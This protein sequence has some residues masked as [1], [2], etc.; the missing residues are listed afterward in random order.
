[1]I[2][3]MQFPPSL[4]FRKI[5]DGL[6]AE[7]L[8]NT[9][10]ALSS[11]TASGDGAGNLN[12]EKLLSILKHSLRFI[13][14]EQ[15]KQL[16]IELLSRIDV[17]PKPILRL[18]SDHKNQ[19]L[20]PS[21]PINIRRQIWMFKLALFDR[22]FEGVLFERY[23]LSRCNDDGALY[24]DGIMTFR[25]I[26]DDHYIELN[27]IKRANNDALKLMVD[28]IGPSPVLMKRCFENIEKSYLDILSQHAPNG[29]NWSEL[30]SVCNLRVDISCSLY[31]H[32]HQHLVAE[33]DRIWRL[34]HLVYFA[35]SRQ[36]RRN[37]GRN[38]LDMA[39][40][41]AFSRCLNDRATT[42]QAAML[43]SIPWIK[44]VLFNS[45]VHL[46]EDVANQQTLPRDSKSLSVLTPI[47]QIAAAP[48]R[49]FR[50]NK[51][52]IC[53]GGGHR[54]GGGPSATT[55]SSSSSSSSMLR[56]AVTAN[57][58]IPK[59][60][61]NVLFQFA[62]MLTA[63]I[64]CD[65]LGLDAQDLEENG[66]GPLSAEMM[67]W[68]TDSAVCGH[69]L[70]YYLLYLLHKRRVH[71]CM[72]LVAVA[73][74]APFECNGSF[75]MN[76]LT[77]AHLVVNAVLKL[78]G[79]TKLTANQKVHFVQFLICFNG[80]RDEKVAESVAMLIENIGMTPAD[81]DRLM[82]QLRG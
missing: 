1:M 63:A 33:H 11:S 20:M 61:H 2:D 64:Y 4:L 77:E 21:F 22:E 51:Q 59:P 10:N 7:F 36:L 25:G 73:M 44:G 75:A 47:L 82:G 76:G 12:R 39:A 19:D 70:I 9:L 48:F 52:H 41:E 14:M 45:Y 56:H 27:K 16:N 32:A 58:A 6:L 24:L 60:D 43:L 79:E 8:G 3:Q 34:V 54:G 37:E 80:N 30:V 72:E 69:L 53:G 26:N 31:D 67:R 40:I 81:C 78:N 23:L 15:F 46:L 42:V 66:V 49:W 74:K 17:V 35:D 38:I 50:A 62:P 18:L 65:S 68:C 29:P 13:R 55:T 5:Y 71:R 57:P 28:D